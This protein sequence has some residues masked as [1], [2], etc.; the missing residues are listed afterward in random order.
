MLII[1]AGV[2]QLCSYWP[3]LL[4]LLTVKVCHHNAGLWTLRCTAHGIAGGGVRRRETCQP[5]NSIAAGC[6]QSKASVA[7]DTRNSFSIRTPPHGDRWR[8]IPEHASA[9]VSVRS[10]PLIGEQHIDGRSACEQI[11]TACLFVQTAD[12]RK[13]FGVSKPC[14]A[15]R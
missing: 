7:T 2:R 13:L 12:R 14:L 10:F 5:A 8:F 4:S 6:A 15:H 11:H 9:A 1:A 3:R